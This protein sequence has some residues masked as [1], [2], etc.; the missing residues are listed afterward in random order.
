MTVGLVDLVAVHLGRSKLQE[1]VEQVLRGHH[2]KD[3]MVVTTT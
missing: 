2:V 1:L 3:S